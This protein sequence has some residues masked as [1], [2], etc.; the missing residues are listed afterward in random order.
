M[1]RLVEGR[2]S[3]EWYDTS[4]TGGHFV[5]AESPFRNWVTVDGAPGPTGK[6][7]FKLSLRGY[8][9]DEDF[10]V[11]TRE[12]GGRRINAF[13]ADTS[14]V[15]R[16]PLGEVPHEGGLRLKRSTKSF[17]LLRDWIAE[18]AHDDPGGPQPVKLEIV[19]GDRVLNAPAKS[20]QLA[21]LLTLSDGSKRDVTPIC[22]YDSS[23]PD[24]AE[25]DA[26]VREVMQ[27]GIDEL[28]AKRRFP[29]L[30]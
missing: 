12:S 28:A 10:T 16:K 1:G 14:V 30:G 17:E 6:G 21:V 15:L 24:I 19:P 18:G 9:P 5:R 20:Q 22:Y 2:W 8:L 13:A 29:V 7:G 26:Y 3:N 25:V 27:A 4:R 23:S 11:L